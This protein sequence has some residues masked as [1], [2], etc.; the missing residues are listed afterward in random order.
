MGVN[1]INLAGGMRQNLSN[2]QVTAMLQARTSQRLATGLRV[3]SAVDDPSAFFAAANHRSRA[4]DLAGRKDSMGEAIQT[5]KAADAGIKAITSLIEQAKGLAASARS[6]GVTD[7]AT[8]ATQFDDLMTQI[9]NIAADSGYKGKN[10]LASDTLTVEF[11]ESGS[12]TLDIVG[13]DGTATAGLGIAAAPS[14]WAA[15][16][17]VDTSVAQ[18]D[19]A[20][21]TM[22]A[23]AKTLASNLG[24][25]TAR[26]EFTS[27]MVNALTEGADN[28][29]AADTN[30]EGANMLALQTRQQLG[31]TSLSLAS[32]ANQGILRLF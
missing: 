19:A 17:N 13:F 3:N 10:L 28:L 6:A 26:Q 11:N 12:S 32:Q 5:V 16:A 8:L 24:V 27:N 2:L 25:V 29:T 31:I 18:L 30:E 20:L 7:R 23:S 9:D 4:N 14:A 1:D 22:R 21:T 15:T